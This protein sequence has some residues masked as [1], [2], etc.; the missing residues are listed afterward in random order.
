MAALIKFGQLSN[1]LLI[2][3]VIAQSPKLVRMT[4]YLIE[5]PKYS[6]LKELGLD[7]EN[8]GVFCGEWVG[9]GEVRGISGSS[10]NFLIA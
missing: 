2:K 8:K 9:S 5:N 7:V 6:W 1:R 4:S 3:H 10:A